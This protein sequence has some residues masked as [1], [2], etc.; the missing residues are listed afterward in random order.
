MQLAPGD[1]FA[2]YTVVEA[3]GAGGMGEAYLARHPRLPRR[4]A[5][6]VPPAAVSQDSTFRERFTREADLASGLWHPNVVSV[7]D[8]GEHGGQL[9][10]AMEFVDGTD[11]GR[12]LV[13]SPTGLPEPLQT[14]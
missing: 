9:W 1:V 5:L 13:A 6:K 11:A 8:R 7:Y 14:N 4:D 12:Q 3:L 2:G 10:I